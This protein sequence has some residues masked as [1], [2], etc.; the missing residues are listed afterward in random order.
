MSENASTASPGTSSAP[1]SSTSTTTASTPSP[2]TKTPSA[3]TSPSKPTSTPAPT[4]TKPTAPNVSE[5]SAPQVYKFKVKIDGKERVVEGTEAQIAAYIQ[6]GEASDARF[7]EAQAVK[8]KFMEL[9]TYAQQNPDK[10]REAYKEL[11]GRDFAEDAEKYLANKYEE[12]TLTD[13]QKAHKKELEEA[14]QA[15]EKLKQYETKAQA[16]A[17]KQQE[18][19]LWAE[20]EQGYFKA[21]EGLGYEK[22]PA[23]LSLLADIDD[24]AAAM[25]VELSDQ[26]LVHEANRRLEQNARHVFKRFTKPGQGPKLLE[27]LG[28]E[29]TK[30]VIM[31]EMERRKMS[32]PAPQVQ[33]VTQAPRQSLMEE[34]A[35]TREETQKRR[36]NTKEEFRRMKFGLD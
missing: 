6:K 3:P 15:K 4:T 9:T 1:S 28:P 16:E 2:V 25:G 27:F 35:K 18:D 17:R 7:R 14:R 5:P 22:D 31:A 34:V 10:A 21:L 26:Q 20:M 13:E 32:S 24:S 8:K 33:E 11:F 30:A 23:I 19:K 36:Q 29:G 12:S